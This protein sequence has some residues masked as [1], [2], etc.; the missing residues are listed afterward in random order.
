MAALN[1]NTIYFLKLIGQYLE[2][3]GKNCSAPEFAAMAD[4]NA[5]LKISLHNNCDSFIYHTIRKWACEFGLDATTLHAYKNRMLFSAVSQL[6]ADAELKEV[7]IAL[8]HAGVRFMLLKGAILSSLYPDPAYRRSCDADIHI[9]EEDT[10]HASEILT[11]RGYQKIP[12]TNKFSIKYQLDATLSIELHTRLFEDFYEKYRTAISA[13]GFGSSANRREVRVLGTLAETLTT[14]HFL[15]YVICH[16]TKHFIDTGITL[17]HLIDIYVF[18]NEYNEQLNWVYIISS[19]ERF[20]IKDFALNLLYICQHYLGMVD[21]SF[22]YQDIEEDVVEM[23]LFDIVERKALDDGEQYDASMHHIVR[24][25]YLNV[26]NKNTNMILA[27]LFPGSKLLT[28]K[29]NYVKK[30]PVMLPIAWIHSAFSLLRRKINGQIIIPP[31]ERAKLT[32][33]RLYL[34]KRVKII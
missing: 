8:N 14:N 34:L 9:S 21:L 20:G 16:H 7:M 3:D 30:H 25:T 23:L 28:A 32:E 26:A 29:F 31:I 2:S 5:I 4:L 15:V 24:E 11:N 6:R 27:N 18:V 19:L 10:N 12:T 33:E 17:R 22:L 13:A 1:L